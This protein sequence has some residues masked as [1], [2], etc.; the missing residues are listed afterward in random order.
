M[1][2]SMWIEGLMR[3][4]TR[5]RWFSTIQSLGPLW[6]EIRNTALRSRA[7][8]TLYSC[9]AGFCALLAA[10]IGIAALLF[11]S[12]AE[13]S[14]EIGIR[15]ALG[16]TRTAIYIEYLFT[17][18]LLATAGGIIGGLVGIPAATVGAFASRWQPIMSASGAD[19]LLPAGSRLPTCS[20]IA[21]SVSWGALALAILLALVIGIAAAL[22]PAAEAAEVEP[23]RAI[24]Q[25]AGAVVRPRQFL[26]VLQVMFGVLVLILLTSGY[27]FTLKTRIA[28]RRVMR[29]ARTA[30]LP[31]PTPSRHSG[32]RLRMCTSN[33]A[34]R[35][36]P[37]SSLLRRRWPSSAG[38][39]HCSVRSRR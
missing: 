13:S 17:S 30:Y 10:G 29:L 36:W 32:N 3:E 23:A 24:A 35:R 31:P 12:V 22:M 27:A 1:A 20:D 5:R 8:V 25:R 33:S 16:A 38:R 37:M 28:R 6:G 9:L 18:A 4:T 14:R 15:R 19:Q 7:R 34:A 39:P 2:I 21:L 26:T 11:V